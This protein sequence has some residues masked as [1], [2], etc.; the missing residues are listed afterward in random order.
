[1]AVEESP[2]FCRRTVRDVSVRAGLAHSLDMTKR[3]VECARVVAVA[4]LNAASRAIG[5]STRQT[6]LVV[7][8]NEVKDPTYLLGPHTFYCV[9][10]T[11]FVRSLGLSRTGV[12]ARDGEL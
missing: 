5:S 11:S 8:L 6:S 2:I 9:I 10:T 1:S 3:R 4:Y 7:I 12:F